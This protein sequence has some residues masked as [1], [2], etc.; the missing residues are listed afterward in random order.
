MIAQGGSGSVLELSCELEDTQAGNMKHC[1]AVD[2]QA[3][4]NGQA[5]DHLRYRRIKK[6]CEP[7]RLQEN[8]MFPSVVTY[9][10]HAKTGVFLILLL[11]SPEL[12][13]PHR[14]QAWQ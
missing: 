2:A 13:W 12:Q 4:R 6:D 7:L 3:E 10:T 9:Q 8:Q 5:S 1:W 14:L 11:T